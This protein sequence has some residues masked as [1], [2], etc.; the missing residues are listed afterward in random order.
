[1]ILKSGHFG[2]RIFGPDRP[3]MARKLDSGHGF[4]LPTA[5][6][7]APVTRLPF[8]LTKYGYQR[9]SAVAREKDLNG[10]HNISIAVL[11]EDQDDVETINSALRDAGHAAHCHWVSTSTKLAETLATENV[12]LLILNCDRY[13]DT[14]RQVIKQKDLFKPEIPLIVAQDSADETSIQD[15]MKAGACDLVSM[16]LKTRLQSVVSREL[17][18][19]RVERALNSTLQS[20]T[21]YKR[22]LKDHMDSSSSSIALV[23]EGIFTDVNEAWLQRFAVKDR[24]ELLGMPIM[25][26]FDTESHAAL[27]G[28]LVATIEGKWQANEKLIVKSQLDTSGNDDVHLEFRRFDLE[29]GPCVQIR[30]AAQLKIAEEP[31]KLVHDALKR[32]P[33]TLFFHRAQFLERINKRLR[34][35]PAQGTHC[36]V[37]IKP[38]NFGAVINSVGILHSEEILAQ[39]AEE[40]R[41]RMHP[42]DVAGRFEGTSMMFLLE[43]GSA[44]DAQAWGKQ[45]CNHI[46]QH[47]FEIDDK[48][49][50]LTCTVGACAVNEVFSS[51]EEFITATVKAHAQGKEAG[52]NTSFLDESADQDTKQREFD[53]IW[54]KHLKAALMEDRFRLAQLPIAGLRSDSVK[55]YDLL[56]RMIDEQG[57]SVLPSEFMPAAERNNMMKN[58]D[59]WMLQSAVEFCGK[60]D[61]DRVFV[62]LSKQSIVDASTVSWMQQKLDDQEFDC[63]RLVIQIPEQDAAKHIKQTRT[64][65]KEARKL[66]IGFA[67]EHY[68]VEQERFQILDILKPDYIKLDGELM[69]T[70]MTDSSLQTAVSKIVNAAQKRKIKTIAER[71]ENAN[72]MAVLFQLGLD[73]MQGHYVHEPEVILQEADSVESKTLEELSAAGGS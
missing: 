12:E 6:H 26:T 11:S 28:A 45:I 27:K 7:D 41:K 63:S 73:F 31:T 4:G 54:V 15:A 17:R 67:L 14:I 3:R 35:K 30:I 53:K 51:V 37:Y 59:R 13:Q 34:R 44:R 10:H 32:D 20:A 62:R 47:T 64:L 42:R 50:H 40:I 8:Q 1:M 16:T 66:G 36:L 71:V 55:M 48:S 29:D 43:R 22:Q 33:T 5:T 46:E 39:L 2:S 18:A 23:Q 21:E 65:V 70:L 25:D 56:V 24:D 19:L 58:I 68:G 61:A 38:D 9:P 57:N 49:A 72:S 60:N 69:H 52:G